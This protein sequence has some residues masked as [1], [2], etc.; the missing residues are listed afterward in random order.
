[1]RFRDRQERKLRRHLRGD[2]AMRILADLDRWQ[3][4]WL[5]RQ[6]CEALWALPTHQPDRK[7]TGQ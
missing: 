6:T 5:T 7:E 4:S 3:A 2:A 1:M